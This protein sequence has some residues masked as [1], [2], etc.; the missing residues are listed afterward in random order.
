M[1]RNAHG[2]YEIQLDTSRLLMI[3][4]TS[5]VQN[6]DNVYTSFN[7][8]LNKYKIYEKAYKK[9]LEVYACH[10][11]FRDEATIRNAIHNNIWTNESTTQE[12]KELAEEAFAAVYRQGDTD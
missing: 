10:Q 2:L 9:C 8:T 5:A 12:E 3:G 6:I 1:T 11:V 4:S 7:L